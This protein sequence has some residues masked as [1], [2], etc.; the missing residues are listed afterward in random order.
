M[1]SYMILKDAEG[2]DITIYGGVVQRSIGYIAAQNAKTFDPVTEASAYNYVRDI[3][4]HVYGEDYIP[5][6]A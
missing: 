1:R 4:R 6:A 3:I 5:K 2:N